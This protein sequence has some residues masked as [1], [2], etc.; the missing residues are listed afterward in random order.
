MKSMSATKTNTRH[1][2]TIV[3][4]L[5]V[6][7]VIAI[8]AA[9]SIV[10]FSGIQERTYDSAVKNDINHIAKKAQVFRAE[11]GYYPWNDYHFSSMS[12]GASKNAYEHYDNGNSTYNLVYCYAPSSQ[13]TSFAVVGYS[14]SGNNFMRTADGSFKDFP[15]GKLGSV[16]ACSAAGITLVSGMDR[17]WFFDNGAWRSYL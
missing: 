9:I 15:H 8:L 5:I 6:I 4:L 2:F 3:E 16:Q 10:A 7:V 14:K 11:H 13:P 1:G 12:L 17:Y